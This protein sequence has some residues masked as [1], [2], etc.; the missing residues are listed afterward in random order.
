VPGRL[1]NEA[2]SAAGVSH[3]K[4]DNVLSIGENG[5]GSLPQIT[6]PA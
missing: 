5:K 2:V 4:D 3:C 1:F 6:N